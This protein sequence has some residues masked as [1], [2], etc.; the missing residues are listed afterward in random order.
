MNEVTAYLGLG[1]NLSD[2]WANLREA[3]R[4]LTSEPGLRLTRCSQVRP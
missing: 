1:T 4:L 3:L 2:R